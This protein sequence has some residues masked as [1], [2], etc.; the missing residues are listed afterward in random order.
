MPNISTLLPFSYEDGYGEF[1]IEAS[2][3]SIVTHPR[4]FSFLK[5]YETSRIFPEAVL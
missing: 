1:F 2:L 3:T 4:F 5:F